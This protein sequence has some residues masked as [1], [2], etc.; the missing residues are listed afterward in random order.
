[1]KKLLLVPGLVFFLVAC[2]TRKQV[3]KA[4]NTG[5]Y[6]Q[7]IQTALKKLRINKDKKRNYDYVIMLQDAYYKVVERDLSTLAHLKK[8]NNPEAYR[9]IYEFYLDLDARQ[10]AIK[11]ILP[12]YINGKQISFKFNNYSNDILEAKENV[13]N[14]MYEKGLA[15]LESD[16]KS[17]IRD[18]YNILDYV[19]SINPNYENT[20]ELLDEAHQ[21]GTDYILVSI[22]NETDQIIPRRL[23]N[24]LLSMDTYGLNKFW[25]T[26]H[27][28]KIK[29]LNYDYTMQL[30]LKQI[31][32]SPERIKEREF[33]REKDV[34][35]GWKYALDE[36]GNVAKDSLGNDI[37]V[38]KIVRVKC[39]YL[40]TIQ[41]KSSQVI[42]DVIYKDLRSNQVLDRFPVNSEFI[43]EYI[44]ATSRGD[45]RALLQD[46]L[47]FLEHRRIPFP[48]NEQ[49]V[50]DTGEDLKLQLK[51]IINSYSLQ[52]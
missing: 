18:A 21:R 45:K 38:D 27:V 4:V 13:S 46:D 37:K 22:N 2:S 41:T 51:N 34:I 5:N 40:E 19:Q 43:F 47:G 26:Y 12:L 17:N 42:A 23:E 35:D 29:G 11:P 30:N 44:Y 24:D 28:N 31:N 36:A 7:A 9:N 50:Y 10:E 16:N 8:D 32:V 3:E 49:M 25:S 15:L 48:N 20:T 6:D 33:I 52:Q 1:M 14:Y 39:R